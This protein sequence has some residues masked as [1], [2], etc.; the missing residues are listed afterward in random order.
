MD[1]AEVAQVRGEGEMRSRMSKA[2]HRARH[3]PGLLACLC[4]ELDAVFHPRWGNCS[5]CRLR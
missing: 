5:P 1:L 3:R 2:E 4:K